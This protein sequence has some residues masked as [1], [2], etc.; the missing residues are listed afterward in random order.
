MF[1]LIAL[2]RLARPVH[3][4][5]A[6]LTFLLGAGIAR[7]LGASVHAD[8][9]WL[10]LTGTVLAQL[11]M[12]LL[13]AVFFPADDPLAGAEDPARRRALRNAALYLSIAALA[14]QAVIAVMLYKDG[15]LTP[16]ALLGMGLS[17]LVMIIY[18]VPPIRLLDRG[19]GELL[20][21]IQIAYLAPSIGFLLQSG[22]YHRLLNAS[23]LPL[24][25]LLLATFLALD[26]PSYADDLRYGRA[27]LLIRMG[28]ERA[29]PLHQGLLIAAYVLL[30]SAM[31]LGFP[32]RLL[33]P[34]FLTVPFAI[35][36]FQFLRNIAL[37][38][39][40]IWRLLS[41]NA[42]AVF[43]LTAYFLTLSFWLR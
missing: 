10:G 5:L 18:A 4:V 7:Y 31:A 6:A 1:S 40:P 43:G 15:R 28:W 12:G 21:A 3:L 32:V 17:L 9:V 33:W 41:A 42:L 16:Y 25:F 20:L 37:G 11:S 2:A 35:L 22:S 36:Q 13:A 23:V 27:T 19:F 24:T 14:A 8:V 26:F 30:A 38:A 29:I 39:R 34:G